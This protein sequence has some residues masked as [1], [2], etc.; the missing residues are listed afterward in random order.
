VIARAFAP[1]PRMLVL[2]APLMGPGTRLVAMK[3]R[4]PPPAGSDDEGELPP[5]W[6]IDDVQ[7]VSVPG[8]VAERHL[9]RL[10]RP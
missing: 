5:G 8:L 1:L 4:W 2:V 7:R 3:G 10:S 6:R 9:V